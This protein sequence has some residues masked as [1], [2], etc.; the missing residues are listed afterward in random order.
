MTDSFHDTVRPDL[1]TASDG[2]ATRFA[3]EA[4][5]FLLAEQARCVM[6]QLPAGPQPA[7]PLTVLEV[8]GGHGQLSRPL[9]ERGCRVW[10]QGSAAKAFARLAPLRAEY[11]RHLH[12]VACGLWRL[13]FA[14]GAF[15]AVTGVRLLAHVT[16]WRGLLDEMTR[17]CRGRL[18]VDF[19]PLQGTESAGA[20]AFRAKRYLEGNT[21]PYFRYRER[22][23]VGHLA[24]RGFVRTEVTRQF[25]LPMVAHRVIGR[26]S[27]SAALE[28]WCRRAGLTQRWGGPAILAAARSTIAADACRSSAPTK[29]AHRSGL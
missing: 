23:L 19:P 15:D 1:E 29:K 11:P 20:W 13:P 12:F 3:G 2:Y 16:E 5:R 24:S 14:D 25:L 27:V 8:G 10:V 18:I 28:S 7:E 26:H 22:D 4:G 21:R 9:L 6:D 17:V